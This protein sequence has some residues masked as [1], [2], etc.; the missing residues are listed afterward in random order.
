MMTADLTPDSTDAE[1][2]RGIA[3]EAGHLLL[4]LRASYG[5]IDPEDKDR[6]TALRKEADLASHH[7]ILRRF[8]ELR[9]HD[10]VLSEEGKDDPVRLRAER[11]WIVDPLDGTR[12]YGLGLVDFAVHIV[13]WAR[14]VASSTG[15]H[16]E[17]STVDL[18]AQGITRSVLDAPEPLPALPTD[19]PLML[20]ASRSRPPVTLERTVELLSERLSSAGITTQGI[21]VMDFG[22]VGGKVN[23]ILCGRAAAYVHDTGFYEWDVAA[24]YLIAQQRGLVISHIGGRPVLFNQADVLVKNLRVAHPRLAEHLDAALAQSAAEAAGS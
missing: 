13:L 16:L 7:H 20:V 19:R 11:V 9:P 6:L 5:D 3:I 21:K 18:P 24:P 23:E 4:D 10:V 8:T 1:V 22:S 17:S 2:S 12:E 15:G 14:D